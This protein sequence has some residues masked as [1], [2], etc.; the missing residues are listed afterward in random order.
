MNTGIYIRVST[1]E[2]AQ[3][4]FSL[5]AQKEKLTWLAHIKDWNII[6]VY[7]DKG[8]SGKDLNRPEIIRMINDIKNKVIENVLVFKIDRLT[9][10]TK[11]LI[12]LVEIFNKYNCAFNS[13]TE[14]IDTT[15][16]TGRMFIKIIGIFA[17]FERENLIERVKLGIDRKVSEGY[18]ICSSTPSYG[19]YKNKGD[20]ILR[21]LK[22]EAI[23]VNLIFDLYLKNYS[24]LQIAKILDRK[25][26]PTKKNKTWTA[27]TIQLILTN[28]NYIGKV[29]HN[30]NSKKYEEINGKHKGIVSNEKFAK[31]KEKIYKNKLLH[32]TK[33]TNNDAFYVN[34]LKC[35][36]CNNNFY[37]KRTIINKKTF[38][39][40]Y[41]KNKKIKKCSQKSISHNRLDKE[42]KLF[43]Q[44]KGFYI[45]WDDLSYELKN[46]FL[47]LTNIKIVIKT[48][49]KKALPI[50]KIDS[51]L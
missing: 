24:F 8:I 22:K 17:E 29:R 9:R 44:K 1:E 3:K 5:E 45:N 4:G 23:I 30:I 51:L 11:D 40:Y 20:N 38:I 18:S 49:E 33:K 10:S 37:P 12:Y 14:S 46:Q 47:K 26:I 15:S 16:A 25:K 42:I 34:Y 50:I 6:N 48:F 36:F 31:V 27:K 39:S 13:L 7:E 28:P 43:L 35:G 41:C 2:Q 32:I 19:Y 21:P